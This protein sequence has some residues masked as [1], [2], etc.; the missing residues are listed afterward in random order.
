MLAQGTARSSPALAEPAWLL[1]PGPA[2][3]LSEGGGLTRTGPKQLCLHRA[4]VREE[5]VPY[6]DIVHMQAGIEKPGAPP[7]CGEACSWEGTW[8]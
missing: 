7:Q 4:P 1:G 3:P 8:S 2:S 6:D 5:D